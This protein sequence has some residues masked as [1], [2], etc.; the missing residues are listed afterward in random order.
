M[1]GSSQISTN[2][3]TF[4]LTDQE[5]KERRA[6]LLKSARIKETSLFNKEDYKK[7]L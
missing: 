7:M 5:K 6:N 3:Q 2:G 4:S 1:A